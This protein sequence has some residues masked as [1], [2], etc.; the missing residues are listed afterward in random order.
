MTDVPE[1]PTDAEAGRSKAERVR[2]AEISPR[3][4]EHP[5]D[6]AAL[7][8]MRKVPGFDLFVRKFVG[9]ISERRLRYLF[10]GSA[11]RVNER[12][13]RDVNRLYAECLEILDVDPRPELFV[14]Q[15]P[16]VN[17]GAVGSDEPF[18]V[19][20]SATLEL[21]DDAE[22]RMVIG[23]ELGH[24]LSGHVLF[25]TM[26]AI[27]IRLSVARLGIPLVGL[28]RFAIITALLEWDRKS[29]LS[30]DRAALLCG[31]DPWVAYRL[32]MKMAGGK[33]VDQMDITEFVAQA[34]EYEAGGDKLDSVLKLLNLSGQRHPFWVLRLAEI[35]RWVER[36]DLQHI[37]D[38]EY[39]RRGADEEASVVDDFKDSAKTYKDSAAE[40]KD[41][42]F[43]TIRDLGSQIAESGSSFFG[44]LFG[45]GKGGAHEDDTKAA[46][47]ALDEMLEEV[48]G[49]GD[50]ESETDGGEVPDDSEDERR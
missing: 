4:W 5:A 21:T 43:Q 38:G 37:L 19:L 16:F 9:L 24:I 42:L 30:S 45:R 7:T 23:H 40:T 10:L 1:T 28:V 47:D 46:K 12:Q 20:N 2:L 29:E 35:K 26:L 6:R 49:E 50:G 8:A 31:Q 15:T 3:A 36:G 32:F 27:L 17:A 14:A 18:I 25:K 39:P 34:E 13:F 41:P 11:V 33:A 44:N 48:G 22:L